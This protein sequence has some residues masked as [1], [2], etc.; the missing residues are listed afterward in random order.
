MKGTI[1]IPDE[2][3]RRVKARTA[4]EGRRIREV[5]ADLY[6]QWLDEPASS[7][8]TPAMNHHQ[9]SSNLRRSRNH[10]NAEALRSRS[11]PLSFL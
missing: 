8:L 2:L 10:R 1:D 5:T 6:Q 7:Q 3:Y 9:H 4:Q 11:K